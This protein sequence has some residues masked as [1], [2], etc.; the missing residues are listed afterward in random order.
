MKDIAEACLNGDYS[1]V[2]T[3]YKNILLA[4][5]GTKITKYDNII[6]GKLIIPGYRSTTFI[7]EI[8]AIIKRITI[9]NPIKIKRYAR[10][11]TNLL[12]I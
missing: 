10:I 3:L 11:S 9:G 6:K 5:D 12:S 8:K 2:D 4:I 1:Q 7:N